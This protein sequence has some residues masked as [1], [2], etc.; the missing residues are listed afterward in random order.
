V[1]KS[2][3]NTVIMEIKS[4][5]GGFQFPYHASGV[6]EEPLEVGKQPLSHHPFTSLMWLED[7]QVDTSIIPQPRKL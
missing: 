2:G 4:P 5:D 3:L 1:S 6:E 7:L